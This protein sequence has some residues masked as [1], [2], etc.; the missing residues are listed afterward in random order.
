MLDHVFK[1]NARE[2]LIQRMNDDDENYD[3]KN[4]ADESMDKMTNDS[5]RVQ[6][7]LNNTIDVM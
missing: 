6:N 4:K 3:D 1:N 5:S 7:L 2:N